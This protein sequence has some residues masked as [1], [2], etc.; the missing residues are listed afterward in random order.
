MKDKMLIHFFFISELLSVH[1]FLCMKS[2]KKPVKAH[3][4]FHAGRTL[5]RK[6]KRLFFF[7][8]WNKL[9]VNVFPVWEDRMNTHAY[10]WLNLMSITL[11]IFQ[12]ATIPEIKKLSDD[13]EMLS[14]ISSIS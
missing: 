5:A 12:G 6:Q 8:W 11:P 4:D 10:G 1:V 3:W 13:F 7:F 9:P 14:G 2:F